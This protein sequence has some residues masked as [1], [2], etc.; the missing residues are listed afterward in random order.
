MRDDFFVIG[1]RI[2]LAILAV[3]LI[4]SWL[5]QSTNPSW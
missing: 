1:N 5:T 2:A 4:V 3:V